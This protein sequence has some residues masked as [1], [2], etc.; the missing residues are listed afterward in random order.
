MF[1]E[2]NFTF[3]KEQPS[4]NLEISGQHQSGYKIKARE[5]KAMQKQ[6]KNKNKIDSSIF[7]NN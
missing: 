2:N 1:S 6:E 7:I 4:L 5:Q 3:E